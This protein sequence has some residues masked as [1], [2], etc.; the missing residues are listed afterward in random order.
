MFTNLPNQS[1]MPSDE[2][3]TVQP[4]EGSK[5]TPVKWP[6]KSLWHYSS[7]HLTDQ[8]PPGKGSGS[9]DDVE[10]AK[11]L[12]TQKIY[13]SWHQGC[14]PRTRWANQLNDHYLNHPPHSVLQ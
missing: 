4:A 10:C 3:H 2:L 11:S 8:S 13:Q 1:K 6:V 9:L 7:D 14:F 12:R 5:D